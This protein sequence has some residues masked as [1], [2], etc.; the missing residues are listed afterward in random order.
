MSSMQINHILGDG[1]GIITIQ[2]HQTFI[3]SKQD[4]SRIQFK[5]HFII[6]GD[7]I[8]GKV[9]YNIIYYDII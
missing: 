1:T 6:F 7:L 5:I 4:T 2:K 8:T 3:V 9:E